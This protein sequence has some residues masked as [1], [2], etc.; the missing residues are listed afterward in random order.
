MFRWFKK[1]DKK[2]NNSKNLVE[3][4][5]S[6]GSEISFDSRSL[7]VTWE[8]VALREETFVPKIFGTVKTVQLRHFLIVFNFNGKESERIHAFDLKQKQWLQTKLIGDK[9]SLNSHSSVCLYNENTIVIFG[10][11]SDEKEDILGILSFN[12]DSNGTNNILFFNN[13]NERDCCLS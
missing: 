10:T 4:D 11:S 6:V 12:N 5:N 3:Q 13:M 1:K 9:L 2:E 7:M 8:K